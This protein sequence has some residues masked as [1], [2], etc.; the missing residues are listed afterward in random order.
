[1]TAAR[2]G[3]QAGEP[4]GSL[5]KG[6]AVQEARGSERTSEGQGGVED[7]LHWRS[8]VPRPQPRASTRE[9]LQTRVAGEKERGLAKQVCGCEC[10]CCRRVWRGR[11]SGSWQNRCVGVSAD[12]EAQRGGG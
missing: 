12:A 7:E 11:R 5:S 9:V 6:L 1:M 3:P 4:G 8:E 10:G 2:E